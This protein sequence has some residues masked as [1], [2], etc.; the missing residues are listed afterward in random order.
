ME[1]PDRSCGQQQDKR[2]EL[3]DWPRFIRGE[4]HIP[5]ERPWL[6]FQQAVNQRN[7][8]EHGHPEV[9]DE[10][11]LVWRKQQEHFESLSALP[12]VT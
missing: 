3:R 2:E 10:S 8:T 1:S 11:R 12:S 6:L 5:R 4:S 7:S 9:R